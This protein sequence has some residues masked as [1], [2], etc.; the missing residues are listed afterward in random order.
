MNWWA[1]IALMLVSGSFLGCPSLAAGPSS[2]K[3]AAENATAHNFAYFARERD[4]ISEADFLSTPRLEGAQI[5]YSWKELEPSA[6]RYD[7]S[8]ITTDLA[9]LKSKHKQLFL[10]IQATTFS[11]GRVAVPKYLLVDPA[12]QGGAVYQ[13]DKQGKPAGWVV[14]LWNPALRARF[15]KL[16]HALGAEFDGKV[17]GIALQETA[18]DIT[19]GGHAP[20][21]GFTDAGYRDAILSQMAALR[22]SFPHSV[23]MQYA[24]FMPG[25]WLL[26]DDRSYLRSVF[27]YAA[28]NRIAI[29]VPD[30]MP[31]K[32]S[33]RNHAYRF[34]HEMKGEL[35][36]GVAVQDGNYMGKTGDASVS[37]GSWP[38]LVPDLA[39]YAGAFLGVNYIF[40]GAQQPFFSHDV[41]PYFK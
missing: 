16:L 41:I 13:Y 25:E 35:S 11:P 20:P 2:E 19:A 10:Q 18:I 40:W 21:V 6:G 33:Y 30:L 34:M 5:L 38:D 14:M 26:D 8:A 28:Q 12:Y 15:Q 3:T 32:A 37:N 4:R 24:N 39:N 36:L 9:Y 29:G 1:G 22:E 31:K 7:F 17:A 27:Q 23:A